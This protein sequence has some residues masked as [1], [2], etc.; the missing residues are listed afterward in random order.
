MKELL[1]I[2]MILGLLLV[3]SAIAVRSGASTPGEGGR[4]RELGSNLSGLLFRVI[5]YVVGLLAVQ[6]AIG[7]PSVLPW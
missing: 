4:I 6:Q 2:G 3:G 5:A 1:L 7:S